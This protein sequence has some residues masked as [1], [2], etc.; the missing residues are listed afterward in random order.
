MGVGAGIG[1][2][3]LLGRDLV[4]SVVASFG[5]FITSPTLILFGSFTCGLAWSNCAIVT[6]FRIA[7]FESVSPARTV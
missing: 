4:F 2:G 1:L 5:T 7:I 6:P 3:F